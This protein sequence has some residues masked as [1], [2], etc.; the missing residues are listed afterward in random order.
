MFLLIEYTHVN[1][2]NISTNYILY[3]S[4]MLY[5]IS[6]MFALVCMFILLVMYSTSEERVRSLG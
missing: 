4:H 1:T 3:G 2:L 5:C 6:I